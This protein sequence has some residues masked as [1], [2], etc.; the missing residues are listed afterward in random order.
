MSGFKRIA[1]EI[2]R[3]SLWQVLGV[4]AVASWVVL[5]VV[6]VLAQN[7]AL[8]EWFPAFA[9]GLLLVGLPIVLATAFIQ[10]GVE[11]RGSIQDVDP[12]QR[13]EPAVEDPG[14]QRL[15]TWR[16]ALAGGVVAFALLGVMAAGWLILGPGRSQ[17]LSG[18]S[19]GAT[20][21]TSIAVLPFTNMNADDDSQ[22]FADGVHEDILAQLTSVD[23]L[24]VIGRQSVMEYRDRN[25]DPRTI[26]E[27]L[28]VAT[29]V[30]GSVRTSGDQVRL[31]ATLID[32]QTEEQLW[33]GTYDRTI[34]DIFEI[35][36]DMASE[37]VSALAANLTLPATSASARRPTES[38]EA[39]EH[40]LRGSQYLNLI[41]ERLEYSAVGPALEELARA[42]ELDDLFAEAHA[43]LAWAL[44]GG[45]A[46]LQFAV[47][48]D[49]S[50]GGTGRLG[51]AQPDAPGPMR[52]RARTAAARALELAP[53]LAEV[54]FA[55]WLVE[56]SDGHDALPHL[57][58]ALELQPGNANFVREMAV[59]LQARG[60]WDEARAMALRAAELDPRV[61]AT[62]LLVGEIER[63]TRRFDEAQVAIENAIRLAANDPEGLPDIMTDRLWLELAVGGGPEG[64]QELFET[65]QQR[66]V[67]SADAFR[68]RFANTPEVL[69]GGEYDA[70]IESFSPDATDALLRCTCYYQKA[71]MY[72]ASGRVELGQV[73]FDSLVA[74]RSQV[75]PRFA[76]EAERGV[77]LT[78]Q[79][80][81]LARAGR[82]DE[83]RRIL[84]QAIAVGVDTMSMAAVWAVN[85]RRYRAMAYAELGDVD[86]AVAELE[87]LLTV[88]SPITP[89][90]LRDRQAWL[91]IR[92]DPKFQ[93]LLARHLAPDELATPN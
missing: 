25:T 88:P 8:P 2:H 62:H 58:R 68:V 28:S 43:K 23:G 70:L 48:A 60:R 3:R 52:D 69:L 63:Y 10:E 19:G 38:F 81:D 73:Y 51:A 45:A 55:R 71:M 65:E 64:V 75:G 79:A 9:L 14:V 92:D 5:Q 7:F 29:L 82:Y 49:A 1:G 11:F 22:F 27:E 34:T 77:W 85:Q 17:L 66:G 42:V 74:D 67:A 21:R 39:Y 33:A 4:Y 47:L 30:S 32:T 41:V 90:S 12:P 35:Q 86:Q 76:T 91:P 87:Y 6:D 24:T 15:L 89:Y 26:G 40:Y 59:A 50:R 72:R 36:S 80:R 44:I 37:I 56:T 46:D 53:D 61:T 54:H 78:L 18:Q 83:G 93:A 13:S 57:R 20:E 16:N 31:V 84:E